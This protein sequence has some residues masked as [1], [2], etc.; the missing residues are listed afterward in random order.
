VNDD[1]RAELL[2]RMNRPSATIGADLPDEITLEDGTTLDV[3]AFVMECHG[4]ETV[5]ESQREAIEDVKATLRR[6]RLRR[7]QRVQREDLSYA[8]AERLVES[9]HG[10]DRALNALEGLDEPAIGEQ[11]RQKRLDD[12]RDLLTLVDRAP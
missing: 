10:L 9:V 3:T 1:E 12:A 7:R 4:L 11:L 2:D 5:P 8:E 6:E